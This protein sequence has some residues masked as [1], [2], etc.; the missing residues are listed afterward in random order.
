MF[1]LTLWSTRAL[2]VLAPPLLALELAMVAL[3]IKEGWLR[4]KVRGWA[5]LWRNRRRVLARRR[6]VQREKLVPDRVWM[7]V[8]TDRLDTPLVALP[9]GPRAVLNGLMRAY[10]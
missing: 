3:A 5:W 1:V 8:L 6:V 7:R 2:L 10:W 9:A 4:Q